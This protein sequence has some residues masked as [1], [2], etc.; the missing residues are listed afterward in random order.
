MTEK[1]HEYLTF[2]HFPF[3]RFLCVFPFP[4]FMIFC[5]CL[6]LFSP[7]HLR[8][9]RGCHPLAALGIWCLPACPSLPPSDD[10]LPGW[11]LARL[12]PLPCR[13]PAGVHPSK[14]GGGLFI[15]PKCDQIRNLKT[16]AA[17]QYNF[18]SPQFS[19]QRKNPLP[20]FL[21]FIFFYAYCAS[22]CLLRDNRISMDSTVLTH[23]PQAS[24][25]VIVH[26][27]RLTY[28]TLKKLMYWTCSLQW[29]QFDTIL[30]PT[31]R[32]IKALAA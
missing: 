26:H 9:C 30:A 1:Q 32:F 8:P 29:R 19:P 31:L 3:I 24:Q 21:N 7:T 25:S 17:K 13:H 5:L 22:S 4:S 16:V 2:F 20:F 23:L 14:T 18:S 10:S 12:G 27:A 11:A 6:F 28:T 15:F